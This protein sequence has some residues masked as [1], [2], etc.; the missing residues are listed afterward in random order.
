MPRVLR[1]LL[2]C[3]LVV[4]FALQQ[5]G[6]SRIAADDC[7]PDEEL[8][9]GATDEPAC[10]GPA[11]GDDCVPQCD[12]CLRCASTPRVLLATLTLPE[13]SEPAATTLERPAFEVAHGRDARLRLERPPRA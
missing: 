3:L 2:E 5:T 7:C 13:L 12:D 6:A 9:A 10:E 1:Y 4:A 8:V 11:D